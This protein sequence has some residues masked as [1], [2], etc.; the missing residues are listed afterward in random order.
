[1]DIINSILLL[2]VSVTLIFHIGPTIKGFYDGYMDAKNGKP[3]KQFNQDN[4]KK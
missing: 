2:L 3:P 1:M 4:N